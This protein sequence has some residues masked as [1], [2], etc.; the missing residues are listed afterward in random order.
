MLRVTYSR[1]ESGSDPEGYRKVTSVSR[2]G[3]PGRPHRVEV[4]GSRRLHRGEAREPGRVYRGKTEGLDVYAG[5]M[6]EGLEGWDGC[7][8]ARLEGRDG[9]ARLLGEDGCTEAG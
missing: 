9:W 1:K 4:G 3:A 6:L 2:A 7:T 8:G 5:A